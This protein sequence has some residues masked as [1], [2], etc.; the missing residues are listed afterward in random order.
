MQKKSFLPF[1]FLLFLIKTSDSYSQGEA[2]APVDSAVVQPQRRFGFMDANVY[3]DTREVSTFTLNYLA[4]LNKRLVYFAFINY[5]QGA[6]AKVKKL[7]D[8]DFFYSEHNLTYT[9]F[10]KIPIDIN[11]QTVFIGGSGNDK[12][13]FAPSWRVHNTPFLDKVCKKL[14]L[15]Y[16]INFHILQFGYH[17]PLDDFTW[18]MEHFYRFSILPKLTGNRIY[19]SGFADHTMGGD[20][21][22]G[23][24]TEH[25]LGIRLFDEF[26]AVAEYR[27]FSYFP[28]PYREGLALGLEYVVLFK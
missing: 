23:L 3:Y 6:I 5:Q 26:H 8:F 27:Y 18:Q 7:D 14:N 20:I 11:V 22:K 21:A 24:V 1:L 15:S 19:L 12:L 13:R 28:E 16:G 4:I 17:P 9:P 25:Q 10:L 2:E